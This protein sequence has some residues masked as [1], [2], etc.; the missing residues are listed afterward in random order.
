MARGK[1]KLQQL[2]IA[3]P[4]LHRVL[5]PGELDSARIAQQVQGAM[6]SDSYKPVWLAAEQVAMLEKL[7]EPYG[8]SAQEAL[9]V[10]LCHATDYPE[11]LH[12]YVRGVLR[13]PRSPREPR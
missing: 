8:M 6:L 7:G 10:V 3:Q 2:D 13:G 9:I 11:D 5:A 4:K 12:A 1:S